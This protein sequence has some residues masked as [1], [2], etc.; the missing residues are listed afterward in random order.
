MVDG[1]RAKVTPGKDNRRH[2]VSLYR[3]NKNWV[4]LNNNKGI[5]FIGVLVFFVPK[6]N[7]F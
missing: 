2:K 7:V 3:R 1:E 5:D 4:K 6:D